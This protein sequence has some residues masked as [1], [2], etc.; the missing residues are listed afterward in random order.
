MAENIIVLLGGGL[1]ST[2][3]LAIA[4]NVGYDLFANSFN[5]G[6]RHKEN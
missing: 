4:K 6:L 2:T 3:I 1:D 5:Y